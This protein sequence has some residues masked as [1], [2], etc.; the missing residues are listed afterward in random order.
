MF[1]C[2]C[3]KFQDALF[4]A[5]LEAGWTCEKLSDFGR[6]AQGVS[7][8]FAPENASSD[9]DPEPESDEDRVNKYTSTLLMLEPPKDSSK[10]AD[11]DQPIYPDEDLLFAK[12][13]KIWASV[14]KDFMDDFKEMRRIA[15]DDDDSYVQNFEKDFRRYEKALD[16]PHWNSRLGDDPE[17]CVKLPRY[18]PI[19]CSPRLESFNQINRVIVAARDFRESYKSMLYSIS[20]GSFQSDAVEDWPVFKKF[21][22][23]SKVYPEIDT[24]AVESLLQL[25][26]QHSDRCDPLPDAVTIKKPQQYDD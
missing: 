24:T 23:S 14:R 4:A 25:C 18:F 1:R 8:N 13:Q 26:R 20:K 15:A 21:S 12:L 2:Y 19:L 17:Y 7:L 11:G 16:Q 22:A 10:A 6:L 3:A 5:E 9:P